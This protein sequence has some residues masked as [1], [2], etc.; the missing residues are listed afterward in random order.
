M[1][2]MPF[3]RASSKEDRE[4]SDRMYACA[5]PQLQAVVQLERSWRSQP[6]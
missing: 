4:A 1:V 6:C 5:K 2:W 3:R